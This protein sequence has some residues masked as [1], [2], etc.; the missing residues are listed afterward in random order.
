[1]LMKIVL[2]TQNQHKIQEILNIWGKVP[3]EILSLSSFPDFPSVVEDGKSFEENSLKKAR[4]LS[5]YSGL[6]AVADDS[7]IEV[8]ALKGAPGIYS[9]RF[10]GEKATDQLNNEKLLKELEAFPEGSARAARFRCVASLV[11][12]KGG[13]F[14]FEGVLEGEV[15]KKARGSQGFGYDPLF[16]LPEQGLTTA[17]LSME[18]K[19]RISHRGQAF[20]RLKEK[21]LALFSLNLHSQ[22]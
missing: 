18:E 13:E 4:E 19:N 7:G 6:M 3:F 8:D 16:Y 11:L 12:P 20:R 21:L 5:L 17:S 22:P 14:T 2:A 10:A 9:A 1:M 15:L